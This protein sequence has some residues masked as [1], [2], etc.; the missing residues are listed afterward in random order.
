MRLLFRLATLALVS[1]SCP[2]VDLEAAA[3]SLAASPDPGEEMAK[4]QAAMDKQINAGALRIRGTI[5]YVAYSPAAEENGYLVRIDA[6]DKKAEIG[7]VIMIVQDKVGRT[8]GQPW[9]ASGKETVI[10]LV[11]SS[12]YT[13]PQH[14]PAVAPCYVPDRQS[15]LIWAFSQ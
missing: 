14:A 10:Y 1:L 3:P 7:K 12:P 9:P 15:A 6:S 8:A 2:A 4:A 11:G 5:L 13:L